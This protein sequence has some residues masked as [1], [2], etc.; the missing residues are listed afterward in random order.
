MTD[1]LAKIGFITVESS[2]ML[3]L[4]VMILS[5]AAIAGKFFLFGLIPWTGI[6]LML[7]DIISK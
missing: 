3:L 2:V 6:V 4:L 5:A 7:I 1:T